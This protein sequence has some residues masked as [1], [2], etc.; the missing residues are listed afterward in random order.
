QQKAAAGKVRRRADKRLETLIGLGDGVA[1]ERDFGGISGDRA[2]MLDDPRRPA[3]DRILEFAAAIVAMHPLAQ[4]VA[5]RH[6]AG[7]GRPHVIAGEFQTQR[8][9]IYF[10]YRLPGL[11][12]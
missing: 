7:P 11:E 5:R 10:R 2:E 8:R 9:A 6:V 3:L 4:R 1:E 12:A